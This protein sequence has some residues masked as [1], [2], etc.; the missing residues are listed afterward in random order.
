MIKM[1]AQEQ[2]P[3][4]VIWPETS[5]YLPYNSALEELD[6]MRKATEESILVFG[7]LR[8]DQANFLKNSLIIENK[9]QGTRF[10]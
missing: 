7:A 6:K 3:D 10:L 2:K 5:L 4:I 8:F 1:T 9:N